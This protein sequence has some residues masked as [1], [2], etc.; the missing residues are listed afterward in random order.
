MR[1]VAI[2]GSTGSIGVNAL[3]VIRELRDTLLVFG[4]AANSNVS[5]VARQAVEFGAK[6]VSMFDPKASKD[7]KSRLNGGAKHLAPGVQGLCDMASHPDVDVVLTSLVG[8]VGF[9]PILAAIRA[10]KVV[11]LANRAHGH[12]RRSSC[13]RPSGGVLASCPWTPSLGHLPVFR[14]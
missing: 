14:A 13:A 11:A 8:G 1:K 4:L 2:L 6:S 5:L 10:G 12:G 7:L 3:N 9:A